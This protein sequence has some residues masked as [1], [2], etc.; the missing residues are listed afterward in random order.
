[1]N[2]IEH[3][4]SYMEG[5]RV[6]FLEGRHK[7]GVEEQRALLRVSHSVEEFGNTLCELVDLSRSGERIYAS[8][9]ERSVS[10]AMRTPA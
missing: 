1:M 8:A 5:T 4:P 9:G 2:I 7:D 3:P 10:K 6:L